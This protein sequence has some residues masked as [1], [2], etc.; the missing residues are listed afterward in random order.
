MSITVVCPRVKSHPMPEVDST[1][2]RCDI[3]NQMIWM[4]LAVKAPD[5]LVCV[6]CFTEENTLAKLF[7]ARIR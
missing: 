4:P 5:H 7:S 2:R 3:C 1:F 6:E